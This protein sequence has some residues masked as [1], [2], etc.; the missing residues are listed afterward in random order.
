MAAYIVVVL[1]I[2]HMDWQ[3]GYIPKT[4]ELLEKHGGRIVA[5][6]PPE[7]LE[8]PGDWA[9]RVVVIE[10][11]DAAAAKA[12]HSDPEYAPMI[13]LRQ[14]GTEGVLAVVETPPA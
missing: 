12:W 11:P 1:K 4:I 5:A 3:A 13:A 7:V 2:K 8:G 6:G 14:S 9:D 10:F